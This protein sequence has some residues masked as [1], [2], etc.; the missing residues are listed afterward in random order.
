MILFH[1]FLLLHIY[2]IFFGVK[3]WERTS[4]QIDI[5]QASN[6]RK[7]KKKKKRERERK[8]KTNQQRKRKMN[9][10]VTTQ[11]QKSKWNG[12]SK[13]NRVFSLNQGESVWTAPRSFQFFI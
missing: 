12:N 9:Q 2:Y 4:T 7:K 13:I 8:R 11:A 5:E 3:Q 6:E 1:I 10:N